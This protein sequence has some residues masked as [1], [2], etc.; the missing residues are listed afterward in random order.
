LFPIVS[1]RQAASKEAGKKKRMATNKTQ[2]DEK[3]QKINQQPF[4]A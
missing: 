3:G 1:R 4:S 2:Q